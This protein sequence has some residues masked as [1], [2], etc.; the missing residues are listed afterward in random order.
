MRAMHAPAPVDPLAPGGLDPSAGAAW[1]AAFDLCPLPMWLFDVGSLRILGANPAAEA[2]YGWSEAEFRGLTL[3]QIRPTEDQERL[4]R[5]MADVGSGRPRTGL[6]WRH[7]TRSGEIIDVEVHATNVQIDGRTLRMAVARDITPRR[8]AA[9]TQQVLSLVASGAPL[10]DV[11]AAIASGVEAL[12]PGALCAVMRLDGSGQCLRL[13]AAPQLPDFFRAAADGL[14]VGAGSAC[15]GDAVFRGERVIA[16][17]ILNDPQWAPYR[18]LVQQAGLAA[19]WS[20]PIRSRAGAV[21]GSIG[22][23]HRQVRSPGAHEIAT[24]AAM[25]QVAAIAIERHQA[26]EALRQTQKLESLGTLAGGIAHDFNNI[27]GAILGNVELARQEGAGSASTGERIEQIQKSALRARLLVQQILAFSRRQATPALRQPLAPLVQDALELLRA[28]LPASVQLQV[29]LAGQL[30]DVEAD[31]TQVQQVLMNLCTNAWHAMAG[32]VGHIE[33][34]VEPAD[35]AAAP[36]GLRPGPCAHLWVRDDGSGMD[37]STRARIFEPFFTTKPVGSGTGLGL[38]VVHGIVAEHHGAI[39]VD[40]APGAGSTFHVWLPAARAE[41]LAATPPPA[42]PGHDNHGRGRRVLIVDDDAVMLLTGEALLRNRGFQVTSA[43]SGL[44]ALAALRA[45][46]EAFDLV[47]T[48]HNMPDCS[49]L[50]LARLLLAVRPGLPLVVYSGYVDAE[51][52]RRAAAAGIAAVVHK[53]NVVEDLAGAIERAL[54][55]H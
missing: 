50:D 17:D 35:A 29:R 38:A 40:T 20:E 39:S 26:D 32:A 1:R 10:P 49:G 53:E 23:Y 6:Q 9:G 16:H 7:R 19:C 27:L 43:D 28:T 5:H 11:L 2:G 46:P 25:A 18:D 34:G 52:Q 44:A 3:D 12:H 48:D 4:H 42:P 22:V 8:R 37:E 24:V 33:V 51:L 13:A 36:P 47:V 15:C 41:A 31:G 30:P 55:A 45:A 21:L 14:P 54:A